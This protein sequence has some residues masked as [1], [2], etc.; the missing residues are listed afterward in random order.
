MK[1]IVLLCC[2]A[3]LLII[4]AYELPAR[5]AFSRRSFVG[6]ASKVGV[7]VVVS[8]L[9]PLEPSNAA[10]DAEEA[11]KTEAEQKAREKKEAEERRIAEET[12]KRLA[13]GRIGRMGAS[14]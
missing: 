3:W 11:K 1:N 8:A 14:Y 4:E 9:S 12:K 2:L 7:A 13:A 5:K 10:I 6:Q